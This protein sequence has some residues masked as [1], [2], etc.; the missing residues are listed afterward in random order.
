MRR[1]VAAVVGAAEVGADS[2]SYQDAFTLGQRLVDGNFRVLTGGLGGIMEAALAGAKTSERY[3]EGD[4]IAIVPSFD[5]DTANTSA[6]IVIATGLD[7][8]MNGLVANADLVVAVAGGAGTLCEIAVALEQHK[9]LLLFAG[10]DG[11][12]RLIAELAS[13]V[14]ETDRIVPVFSVDEAVQQIQQIYGEMGEMQ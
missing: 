3:R 10:H 4:T 8:H 6:D 7:V 1:K 2:P 5:P 9:P 14:C 12:G 11:S 13:E